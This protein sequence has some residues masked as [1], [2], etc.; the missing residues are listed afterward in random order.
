[1]RSLHVLV[2]LKLVNSYLLGTV[3]LK[4]LAMRID[5]KPFNASTKPKCFML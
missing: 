3:K 1:L 4:L 2:T 5:Q